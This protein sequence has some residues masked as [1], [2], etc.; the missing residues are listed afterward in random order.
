MS[1]TS[2]PAPVKGR[3]RGNADVDAMNA[4]L[5][6]LQRAARFARPC[7]TDAHMAERVG[8]TGAEVASAILS[9][10]DA[11]VIRVRAMPAPTLRMVTIVATGHRTGLVQGKSK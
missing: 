2:G 9:L 10:A 5:P 8:L 4:V 7:P 3:Q 6:L 1:G 11:N